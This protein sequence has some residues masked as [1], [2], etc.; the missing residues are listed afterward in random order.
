MS[1]NRVL[2]HARFVA[3]QFS[4]NHNGWKYSRD[5]GDLLYIRY[6]SDVTGYNHWTKRVARPF[7][8]KYL[9][10]RDSF[11]RAL[12]RKPR[13]L[14]DQVRSAWAWIYVSLQQERHLPDGQVNGIITHWEE[15]G[16]YIA[17]FQPIVGMKVLDFL[18]AEPDHPHAKLI[19]AEME[20]ASEMSWPKKGQEADR[21]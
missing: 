20:R 15:D 12:P 9:T 18:E 4:A 10:G 3:E 6:R 14:R 5:T 2:K 17:L 1:K 16:E 11:T 19:L 7:D 21:G 8:W 13:I